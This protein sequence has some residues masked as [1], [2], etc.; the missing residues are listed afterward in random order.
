MAVTSACKSVVR[1]LLKQIWGLRAA[2]LRN[3]ILYY[4]SIHP[5][6]PLSTHPAVFEQ[7]IIHAKELGYRIITHRQ[8]TR[9]TC[10]ADESPWLALGF[11]DGYEDNHDFAR[12]VLERHGVRATFF[13]VAGQIRQGNEYPDAGYQLYPNRR[14]LSQPQVGSL[15][16]AGHEI[17]SHGLQHELA[18]AVVKAGRDLAAE[19]VASRQMLSSWAGEEVTSY[20][21]PNGQNG[22]YSAETRAATIAAGFKTG[23]V[24]K[25]GTV[26]RDSDLFTLPRCEVAAEDTTAD[27]IKKITGK[28]DYL[29]LA[30]RI[31]RSPTWK[32]SEPGHA[33]SI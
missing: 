1:N 11:D 32:P 24:T 16:R 29:H 4:H 22:A 26:K 10:S 9:A 17:A 2:G 21:Y 18:T 23:S 30:H 19:Y 25:W 15:A 5:T 14:M 20:S 8:I 12:P 6:M 27:L 7:H 3:R 33:H 31:R 13:V 28:E